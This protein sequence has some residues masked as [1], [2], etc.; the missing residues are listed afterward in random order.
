MSSC[1]LIS[2]RALRSWRGCSFGRFPVRGRFRPVGMLLEV[3]PLGQP[4]WAVLRHC[5]A[6]Q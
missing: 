6:G 1:L 3:P 4:V 2:R 5:L